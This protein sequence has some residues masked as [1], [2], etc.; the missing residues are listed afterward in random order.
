MNDENTLRS[1]EKFTTAFLY[2]A[3]WR[4][5]FI[6]FNKTFS[7]GKLKSSSTS[8]EIPVHNKNV[9]FKRSIVK[10]KIEHFMD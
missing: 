1:E 9:I 7:G 8:C 10:I 4:W 2:P 5:K 6:H 3:F